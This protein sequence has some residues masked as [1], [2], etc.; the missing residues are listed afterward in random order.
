MVHQTSAFHQVVDHP[1]QVEVEVGDHPCQV[2]VAE[3]VALL[4]QVM[5][6]VVV[7][8]LASL[9]AVAEA[10]V[11][12]PILNLEVAAAVVEV[13]GHFLN[14]EVAVVVESQ[15]HDL[16][17]LAMVAVVECYALIDQLEWLVICLTLSSSLSLG[18]HNLQS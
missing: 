5:V 15:Y 13:V 17:I 18:V 2:K 3:V 6:V 10:V 4:C 11:P 16:M 8:H 12:L 9:E 14:L 7:D 1:Y